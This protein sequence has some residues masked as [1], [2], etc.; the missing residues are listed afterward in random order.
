MTVD[1]EQ[2]GASVPGLDPAAPVLAALGAAYSQTAAAVAGLVSGQRT[3]EER[4]AQT[5]RLT[6]ERLERIASALEDVT[7][8]L[9][10]LSERLA[11]LE[12]RR[13]ETEDRRAVEDAEQWRVLRTGVD[14]IAAA[15]AEVAE[16]GP[17]WSAAVVREAF[18]EQRARGDEQHQAHA[19]AL[20]AVR[21]LV[22]EDGE[23]AA[24]SAVGVR[25]ALA[26]LGGDVAGVRAEVASAGEA[27]ADA[28]SAVRDGVILDAAAR[29]EAAAEVLR[30]G[31]G[32]VLDGTERAAAGL[33]SAVAGL[34]EE[35]G[36]LAQQTG[37]E[38][39]TQA[40]AFADLQAAHGS[41][42]RAARDLTDQFAAVGQRHVDMVAAIAGELRAASD[43]QVSGLRAE[44]RGVPDAL[45]SAA[46]LFDE[47]AVRRETEAGRRFEGLAARVEQRLTALA[48]AAAGADRLRDEQ[49]GRVVDQ[50]ARVVTALGAWERQVGT[51][52]S[53]LGEARRK[54][55][56]YNRSEA[57]DR[58]GG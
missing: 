28:L 9:G 10:S 14:E 33:V 39:L 12:G 52:R 49:I 54:E 24:A 27:V 4:A 35:V 26:A 23:R 2:L 16:A 58:T 44:V 5:D 8:R 53:E 6:A 30:G 3:A 48:D 29:Q 45:T 37:E 31:L 7:G 40:R 34:R 47:A 32:Q 21:R 43:A 42:E 38:R 55:T 19:V 36:G 20:E 51:L 1:M 56:L 50:G 18:A 41:S 46:E 13:Q 57:Y 15:V 17:T 11:D 22:V 25:E